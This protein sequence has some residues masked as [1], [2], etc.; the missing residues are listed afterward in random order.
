MK[1]VSVIV[2]ALLIATIAYTQTTKSAPRTAHHTMTRASGLKWSPA[3]PGFELAVVSGDLDKPGPYILRIRATQDHATVAPHW[4]PTDENITVL[5]GWFKVGEGDTVDAKAAHELK[6][7]DFAMMPARMHHWGIQNKGG[8]L[9]IHGNGPF[10]IMWVKPPAGDKKS[11]AKGT[12][13]N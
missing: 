4:H 12:K 10:K 9:Q 13:T 11:E 6:E 7:G 5:S 8:I 3:A 2:V 1:R